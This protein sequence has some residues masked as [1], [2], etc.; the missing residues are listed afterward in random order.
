MPHRVRR[1]TAPA[2]VKPRVVHLLQECRLVL[3][4]CLVGAVQE[5]RDR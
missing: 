5:G 3:A 2:E 4:V 1:K